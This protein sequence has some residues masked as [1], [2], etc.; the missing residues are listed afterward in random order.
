MFTP[1][2][3]S[4]IALQKPCSQPSTNTAQTNLHQRR[5]NGHP[6]CIYFGAHPKNCRKGAF[7]VSIGYGVSAHLIHYHKFSPKKTFH[8]TSF[9]FSM[10]YV[11]SL[12][13]MYSHH[14]THLQATLS[15]IFCI[16]FSPILYSLSFK[17]ISHH[18]LQKHFTPPSSKAF[19]TSFLIFCITYFLPTLIQYLMCRC[20]HYIY[21]KD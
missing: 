10:F 1:P 17:S 7:G 8:A 20:K 18:L 4:W 12:F 3:W 6:N 2:L 21:L 16:I 19:Y 15:I 9:I 11:S 5:N 14:H 13:I